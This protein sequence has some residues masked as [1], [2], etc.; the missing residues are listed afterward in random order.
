M[1]RIR[2][3]S[4]AWSGSTGLFVVVVG[5]IVAACKGGGSSGY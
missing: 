4:A 5:L 3:W 2:V 1:D